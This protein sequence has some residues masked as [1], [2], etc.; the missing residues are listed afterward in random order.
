[1][2]NV[3]FLSENLSQ[4]STGNFLGPFWDWYIDAQWIFR[5]SHFNFGTISSNFVLLS[6]SSFFEKRSARFEK[7]QMTQPLSRCFGWNLFKIDALSHISIFPLAS[8]TGP[9]FVAT[10]NM[11]KV[12]KS[13]QISLPLGWFMKM[14]ENIKTIIGF[15]N[16]FSL[17]SLFNRL[18]YMTN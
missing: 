7:S 11:G 8:W 10:R 4:Y 13:S 5:M 14:V 6:P 15:C 18:E 1:M 3:C 17:E 2:G 16:L 12:H 9:F